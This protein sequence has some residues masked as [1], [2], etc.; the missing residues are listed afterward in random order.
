MSGEMELDGSLARLISSL[1]R[2]FPSTR[3]PVSVL[4][5]KGSPFAVFL[6]DF[7]SS[8]SERL[9]KSDLSP[10][11]FGEILALKPLHVTIFSN[12]PSK[13]VSK[14]GRNACDIFDN[15]LFNHLFLGA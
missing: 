4:T 14:A 3:F 9:D 12:V 11:V 13:T 5:V 2:E 10:V 1:A 15:P 7:N 8:S 6:A